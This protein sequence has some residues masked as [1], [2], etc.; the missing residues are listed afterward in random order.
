MTEILALSK[1][2]AFADY[3]FIVAQ[4]VQVHNERVENICE[5]G[6]N[7]G[8]SSMKQCFEMRKYGFSTFFPFPKIYS[9]AFPFMVAR[10]MNCLVKD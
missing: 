4:M 10:T 8:D 3:N 5:K 6:E 7:D 1:L 9:K 2:R